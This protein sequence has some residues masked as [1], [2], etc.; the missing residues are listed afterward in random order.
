LIPLTLISGAV[1]GVVGFG[2]AWQLQ[3]GNITQLEL[4]NANERIAI[5]RTARQNAERHATQLATAQANA[6]TRGVVLRAAA[7]SAADVGNGLRI[8]TADAVRT[9]AIDPAA[10]S[11]TAATLGKLFTASTDEYRKLAEIADR[12]ASDSQ[13]LIESWP[14]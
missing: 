9:A 13:A 2:L 7:V 3:A 11:D 1:A 12:H 10:C 4:D 14:R 6:T 5:Q 8:K